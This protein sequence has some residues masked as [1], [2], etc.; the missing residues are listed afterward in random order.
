MSLSILVTGSRGVIG[1]QLCKI[2]MKHG[3]NVIGTCRP[4]QTRLIES[5]IVIEPWK[6]LSLGEFDID[7]VV[8]LAGIYVTK[9]EI[10]AI[11]RS[12]FRKNYKYYITHNSIMKYSFTAR[13][14]LWKD[15]SGQ[16]C[17]RMDGAI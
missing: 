8:H 5:E 10:A 11:E 16:C 13:D 4:S 12:P 15:F 9:Y 14:F 2:L 1:T 6:P 3:H 7:L 17:R